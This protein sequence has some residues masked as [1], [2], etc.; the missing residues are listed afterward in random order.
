MQYN[1]SA[2]DH[3]HRPPHNDSTNARGDSDVASGG[4]HGGEPTR[5]DASWGDTGQP[6]AGIASGRGGNH[7]AGNSHPA[8]NGLFD[9]RAQH[10]P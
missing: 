10:Y 5:R 4:W 1:G 8:A 2:G 7:D 9:G 6:E 3:S